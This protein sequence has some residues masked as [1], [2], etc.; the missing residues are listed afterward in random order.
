MS[1]VL[2]IGSGLS[3]KL[4]AHNETIFKDMTVVAVNHGHLVCDYWSYW[5]HA[6]DYK[7]QKPVLTPDQIEV[8]RYAKI[9]DRYGGHRACGYSIMLCASYWALDT[10]KP[11]KMYYLGAD[12]NYTPQPDGSTHIYGV[13]L[14]IKK[15][16]PDPDRMAK[17]YAAKGQEPAEYL[18]EVYMRFYNIAVEKGVEVFNLS[19]DPQ[20]RL[21]Y[22]KKSI[23]E[24]V[25]DKI[26]E[27]NENPGLYD[28]I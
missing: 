15:G 7:G 11:K 9:L 22:P 8:Y 10:L 2:L 28:S 24:L 19:D 13:G 20:S 21:P 4:I 26:V 1:E 3:A 23:Q 16:Q 6:P 18:R 12:M 5:V 14:D 27:N 17:M 25:L